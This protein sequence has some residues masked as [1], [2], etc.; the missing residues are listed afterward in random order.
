MDGRGSRLGYDY[1]GR[2]T[3]GQ[4]LSTVRPVNRQFIVNMYT[5]KYHKTKILSHLDFH[6]HKCS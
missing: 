4:L 5:I 3:P 6:I 1:T 2:S